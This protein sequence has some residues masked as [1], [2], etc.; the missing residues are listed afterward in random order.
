VST[1]GTVVT[2]RDQKQ[3]E[4]RIPYVRDRV[5]I[6]DVHPSATVKE[7]HLQCWSCGFRGDVVDLV[8]LLDGVSRAE[9]IERLACRIGMGSS[10]TTKNRKQR[11]EK[12]P[13]R[14]LSVRQQCEFLDTFI[15]ARGWSRMAAAEGELSVVLDGCRRPRVRFPYRVNG[16]VVW[17]QDRAIGSATP[18]WLNPSGLSATIYNADRGFARADETG[19][20]W[21]LEGAAD[22]VALRST[23]EDPAVVGIPGCE[24]FRPEWSSAFR[25]LDVFILSD[26]DVAGERLREQLSELLKT[27]ARSVRHVRVPEPWVDFDEWRRACSCDNDRMAAELVAAAS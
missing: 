1:G 19:G 13:D 18:K 16:S 5:S 24:S 10:P 3:L 15:H 22:V 26:R 11:S 12:V 20:C 8:E 2:G 23:Y 7:G 9:A 25:D 27:E 4:D 14:D 6:E 17:W 21:I